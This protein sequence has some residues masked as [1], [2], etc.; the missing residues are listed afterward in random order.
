[1]AQLLPFD[2]TNVDGELGAQ[3][4]AEPTDETF[5]RMDDVGRVVPFEIES[6]GERENPTGAV[7][8]AV[9]ATLAALLLD[10]DRTSDP[11]SIRIVQRTS[12]EFLLGLDAHGSP[13]R[14]PAWSPLAHT[15]S[16]GLR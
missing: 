7:F 3:D 16:L 14:C 10:V 9:G 13:P 5:L 6:V 1:M 2:L 4:L 8:N 11:R 15:P 12:P